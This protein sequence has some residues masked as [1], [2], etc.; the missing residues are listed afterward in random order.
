MQT[1]G[2]LSD[3]SPGEPDGVP[4]FAS[5]SAAFGRL[6]DQPGAL[7]ATPA[8]AAADTA[9]VTLAARAWL[10]WYV[11]QGVSQPPGP[12][13]AANSPAWK[14]SRME[15]EFAVAART[16]QGEV[17][18]AA[19]EYFEGRLDWPSFVVNP[20]VSFN[21]PA[22]TRSFGGRYLPAPVSFRGMPASRFWEFEDARIDLANT[23]GQVAPDARA[24][25]SGVF[26]F[27]SSR[28]SMAMTGSSF[29]SNWKLGRSTGCGRSSSPIPLAC[30]L[31]CRTCRRSTDRRHHG[32]CSACHATRA[33]RLAPP[34]RATCSSWRRHLGQSLEGP[35]LEDVLFLR[36]EQASMG[37]A[38]ERVVESPLGQP[39][40]RAAAAN[41]RG[42]AAPSASTT[43]D[44]PSPIWSYRLASDVPDNWIPFVPGDGWL[45]RAAIPDRSGLL[46]GPLGRVLE[47]RREDLRMFDEE[48][49]NE[50][51]RVTRAYQ[52]ARWIDGSLHLWLG[53]RKT[54]GKAPGSSGLRFDVLEPRPPRL[55]NSP[56]I[57]NGAPPMQVGVRSTLGQDTRVRRLGG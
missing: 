34:G 29:Q 16:S 35:L 2:C 46:R 31:R 18:L 32:E 40:D 44:G 55:L 13:T 57:V 4:L 10:A 45:L 53:R 20:S 56:D 14:T 52:L 25:T 54:P 17:V 36:D 1:V 43:T 19:P 5:L 3:C 23:A 8:I 38:V 28:S 30:K 49:P 27:W 7:P 15:Y 37:W 12:L 51:A 24:A 48:I 21:A 41:A 6:G 33:P 42:P 26:Y 9:K 11:E 22:D 50:G 39:L 47:P